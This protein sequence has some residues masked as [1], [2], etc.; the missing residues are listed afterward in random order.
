MRTIVH[1]KTVVQAYERTRHSKA[2]SWLVPAMA[3]ALEELLSDDSDDDL[4][5][6]CNDG[7]EKVFPMVR[8]V[9]A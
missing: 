7:T 5:M 3:E 9:K 2:A 6:L 8:R 1:G 4:V